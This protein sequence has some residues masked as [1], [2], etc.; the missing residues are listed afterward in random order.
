MS[1][2]PSITD[3][4]RGVYRRLYSGFIKGQRINKL[5]LSA[6]AWF[7]RVLAAVDDLGNAEADPELCRSATAG[8]RVVTTKQVS[9]WLTEMK[10]AGLISL[11]KAKGEW[12]LHVIGFEENQP[13]GKNGKRIQR[14]PVPGESGCIRVNPD[15]SSA[16]QASDNDNEYEDDN[17]K[18]VR[19]AKPRSRSKACDEEYLIELQKDDAYRRLNVSLV[20]AKM[21]RWCGEKGKQ[22]T[23]NRLLGWLNREDQPMEANGNGSNHGIPRTASDRNVANIKACLD[24][25]RERTGE[26]DNSQ[27]A[28]RIASGA[29]PRRI[30]GGS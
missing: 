28:G 12:Y 19:T 24:I 26:A 23:R 7:W 2:D 3:L 27:P 13:A 17:E 4:T 14:V 25:I 10:K 30:S 15:V 8:R 5:S 22:P 29:E 16:S 18:M 6:E 11:Y 9:S 21:V 20:H 1:Q